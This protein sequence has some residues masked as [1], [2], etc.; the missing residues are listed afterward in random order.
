MLA[1]VPYRPSLSALVFVDWTPERIKALR[2][3]LGFTQRR[4]ARALGY[5]RTASVTELE[6]G[7]MDPG[8]AVLRLLDYLDKYG[9][10]P[11][12]PEGE[13]QAS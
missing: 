8:G 5:S 10:L 12:R 13:E 11:D 3:R 7:V 6:S 2:K 1:A 9:A 4:M